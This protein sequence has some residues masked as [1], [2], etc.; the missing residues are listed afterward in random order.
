MNSTPGGV[1]LALLEDKRLVELHHEANDAAFAVGD[2]VLGKIVRLLPGLNAAFVDIGFSR[3]AFIH[4]TDL[5]PNFRNWMKFTRM[6]MAGTP[7]FSMETF[8][9]EQDI[10]KG[11][12]INNVLARKVPI[13]AQIMKEPI[14]SKG[15][16]LACDI[17]LPGRYVVLMPFQKN[18]NISR[19]ITNNEERKRLQKVID[20]LLPKNFGAIVRTVAEGKAVAELQSDVERLVAQWNQVIASLKNATAP[21]KIF[22]EM[23]K[24]SS[25]LRDMLNP[26]FNRIVLNTPELFREVKTYINRI[27]PEKEGI[28][29]LYQA[30]TPVF[31]QFEV[32][33]QVKGS[34]GKT[35]NMA[36]GAYL[37]IE[38][39]EALHVVDVNSGYRM[40][41]EDGQE[42]N[43]MQVNLEA[44]DEI[45]RQLRLRD[46]GGIVV[47]DF[48][49]M[50][51]PENKKQIYQRMMNAMKSD[52]AR[53]TILPLSK[54]N[55]LQITRQR[56]KPQL[57]IVTD[58]TCPSC[59]GTGKIGPSILVVDQIE[60]DLATLAPKHKGLHLLA[61]PYIEGYL[62]Q[63]FFSLRYKWWRKYGRW[64][65]LDS[66]DSQAITE[67]QFFDKNGEEVFARPQA[68]S[69]NRKEE[70][71]D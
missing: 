16:R 43:A 23:N 35:V 69:S 9:F 50:R 45:A 14:S 46:I 24:T 56:V 40:S 55:I 61:H 29:Q 11:G 36:S 71:E 51:N 60:T 65:R 2:I 58:E 68:E 30:K 32:T 42:G 59:N 12:R 22:S 53:H 17:S 34:F 4:Y 3:N 27:A 57:K 62:R 8:K 67:F 70:E 19:K 37:V 47:I 54:F 21:K 31:D 10:P 33:R 13:L 1:E 6:A 64:L 15:H 44:V 18:V 5:G 52:K 20:N 25:I 38:H 26:S 41:N 66:A 28:V 7:P 63:G 39:T 49:D 48:I